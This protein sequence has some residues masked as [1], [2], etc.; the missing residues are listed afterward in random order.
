MMTNKYPE[1]DTELILLHLLHLL[2]KK[3]VPCNLQGW[4]IS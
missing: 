2:H 1:M 3:L 4:F